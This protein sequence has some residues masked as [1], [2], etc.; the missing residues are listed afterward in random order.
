MISGIDLIDVLVGVWQRKRQ[1][2]VFTLAGLGLA[3]VYLL[4]ADRIYSSEVRVFID[5]TESELTRPVG[6]NS[7]PGS[8]VMF[9]DQAVQSQVEILRS[10]DLARTVVDE[11]DLRSSPE[12]AEDAGGLVHGLLSLAGLADG[13]SQPIAEEDFLEKYYDR[14][15]VYQVRESRVIGVIFRAGDPQLAADVANKLVDVYLQTK[16]EAEAQSTQR[17]GAWLREQIDTLRA[18]VAEAEARVQDFRAKHGL[19]TPRENQSLDS[20]QLAELNSELIR[21]RTQRAEAQVRAENLRSMIERG[22]NIETAPEVVQSSLMQQLVEQRVNLRRRISEL[23]ATLG[24]RHPRLRELRAEL[25]DLTAQM[26]A[27]ALK[28]AQSLENAARVATAREQAL[29]QSLQAQIDTTSLSEAQRIELRALEREA[30]TQR[31]LLE[32]Y[33]TRFGE[34][35]ARQTPEVSSTNARVISR[36]YPS[37]EPATP[38]VVG[39]LALGSLGG[40]LLGFCV[41]MTGALIAAQP[42]VTDGDFTPPSAPERQKRQP[43][44]FSG[45]SNV[46]SLPQVTRS[47]EHQAKDEGS[48]TLLC[49]TRRPESLVPRHVARLLVQGNGAPCLLLET[50]ANAQAPGLSETLQGELPLAEAIQRDTLSGAHVIFG[51][52]EGLLDEHMPRLEAALTALKKAYPFIIVSASDTRISHDLVRMVPQV[53]AVDIGVEE[54]VTGLDS[55]QH[56]MV[57]NGQGKGEGV[58]VSPEDQPG[59]AAEPLRGGA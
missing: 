2:A 21:V 33:L 3:L 40:F 29:R 19:Y 15:T 22:D 48:S 18:K 45:F 38:K 4:M 17:A 54:M 50:A 44:D 30:N 41:A 58:Q 51:G 55:A 12:F 24:P 7:D 8:Q 34:A 13:A 5:R 11:L 56:V 32:V 31:E 39:S 1:V 49:L 47:M 36:A 14:L 26:R 46:H 53:L 9:D 20:Q 10:R 42:R 23:S 52:A 35:L 16:R 37:A 6:Q 43:T 57:F 59:L 25:E 27:E 28:I